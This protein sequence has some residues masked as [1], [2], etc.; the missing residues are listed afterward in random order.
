MRELKRGSSSEGAQA[1]ELKGGKSRGEQAGK[2]AGRLASTRRAFS[3]SHALE[4][5]VYDLCSFQVNK[6]E[7]VEFVCNI[8]V[9]AQRISF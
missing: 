6:S 2:K 4:G 3:R 1:R 8:L 5:L 9:V 7:D